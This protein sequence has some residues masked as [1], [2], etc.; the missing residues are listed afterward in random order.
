MANSAPPPDPV[1]Q[2]RLRAG[3]NSAIQHASQDWAVAQN[4]KLDA[5]A[6]LRSLQG[7]QAAASLGGAPAVKASQDWAIAAHDEM[8][9]EAKLVKLQGKVLFNCNSPF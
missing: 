8:Y 5:E 7:T 2:I 6:K 3:A 4:N 9:A 1:T